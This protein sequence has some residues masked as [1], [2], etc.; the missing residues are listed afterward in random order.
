[1][2]NPIDRQC[3]DCNAEA[4]EPCRPYCTGAAANQEGN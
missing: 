2:T 3:D 4:S 1:M